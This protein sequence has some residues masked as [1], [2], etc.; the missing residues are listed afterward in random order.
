M[1]TTTLNSIRACKAPREDGENRCRNHATENGYCA[2][3]QNCDK[4]A[5]APDV[6]LL[7]A[8]VNPKW[9][10]RLV[11]A[12]IRWQTRDDVALQARHAA[13]AQ[14]NHRAPN[15]IRDDRADSGTPVFGPD[16]A[17]LVSVDGI[18]DHLVTAGY[19]YY[20][21]HLY[22]KDETDR[23]A[24]LVIVMSKNEPITPVSILAKVAA[25]ELTQNTAWEAAHVW[26]NGKN[27]AGM[28]VHTINLCHR[29][30]DTKPEATLAF[31]NGLWDLK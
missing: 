9:I 4:T 3:H 8:R 22:R 16:G 19:R 24:T 20:D 7:K 23:M 18:E 13:M 17:K 5:L 2:I 14:A 25:R 29:L 21:I 30:P 28:I 6:V 26:A 27:S 31:A 10:D 1:S 11:K 12:D 15:A